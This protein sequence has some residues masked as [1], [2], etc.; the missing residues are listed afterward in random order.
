MPTPVRRSVAVV[1]VSI[2]LGLLGASPALAHVKL[3]SSTPA[4]Q[5]TLTAAP[6]TIELRFSTPM[7]PA[8]DGIEITKDGTPVPS[9]VTQPDDSRLAV[10]PE[11]ALIDGGYLLSWTVKA[12]DS[13]PRSGAIGFAVAQ[14]APV[15]PAGAAPAAQALPAAEPAQVHPAGHVATPP[16][17]GEVERLASAEW[18]GRGARWLT[19]M[20]ALLGIGVLAFAASSLTGSVFEVRAA[21][22]WVR[23]AGLAVVLGTMLEAAAAGALLHGAWGMGVA[24]SGLASVLEGSFLI[25]VLLRIAGGVAMLFGAQ[26]SVQPLAASRATDYPAGVLGQP[27]AGLDLMTRPELTAT[28]RLNVGQSVIALAGAALVAVSYLFD[29]HTVTAQPAWLVRIADVAHVVGAGVWVGGV[30]MMAWVLKRRRRRNV[31][32]RAGELA[33]RFSTVAA[34]ALVIVAVAG[35]FLSF[36]ILDSPGELLSTGFGRLLLLKVTAVAA[37]A[38]LGGY[39]FRYVIPNLIESPTDAG[40]SEQLRATVRMEAFILVAVVGITAALVAA[41]T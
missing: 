23:R 4:D 2:A 37:A 15:A 18:T 16:H 26:L 30:A 32:L 7:E 10:E 8:G 25:A 33:I 5:T 29:G 39:N 21:A 14:P 11:Q 31:A 28:H 20:G 38:A 13:H 41:G 40:A 12:G 24:P 35:V 17:G 9:V 3:V 36:S 1:A 27:T 19:L 22:F 34:V 6:S